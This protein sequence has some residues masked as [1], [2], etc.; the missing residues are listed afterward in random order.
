[1]LEKPIVILILV[2]MLTISFLFIALMPCYI[3][4]VAISDSD[5]GYKIFVEMFRARIV[6]SIDSIDRDSVLVIPLVHSLSND[7]IY[8]LIEFVKRGGKLVILDE[9]GFSRNFFKAIG[10][11]IDIVNSSILDEVL[12][13]DHRFYPIVTTSIDNMSV[14]MEKPHPIT[15][16]CR[17]YLCKV[18]ATSSR[19]SYLDLDDDGIYDFS[20]PMKSFVVGIEV[21]YFNGSIL[22]LSD[23]DV[24]TNRLIQ[25][26][27]LFIERICG[28]SS[29]YIYQDMNYLDVLTRLKIELY[30]LS[31]DIK[32]LFELM[33]L[34]IASV[35]VY[36][37]YKESIK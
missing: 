30:R 16:K 20:E 18:I 10:I 3:D 22:L 13:L 23:L 1:M 11:S 31:K 28:N 5:K 24:L 33:L 27:S 2:L 25:R 37:V 35:I 29:V 14:V 36:N 17:L 6:S 7:S 4:Y 21:K 12:K 26:N 15:M 8:K 34:I 32:Y 9:E 19:F